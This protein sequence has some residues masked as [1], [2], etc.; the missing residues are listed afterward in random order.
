MIRRIA[1]LVQ[2]DL[3][4]AL[5]DNIIIY[6]LVSPVLLAVVT[7]L[8]IPSLQGMTM[9]FALDAAAEAKVIEGFKAYGKVELYPGRRAGVERVERPDDVAGVVREGDRYAVVVE[10]NEPADVGRM[11]GAVLDRILAGQPLAAIERVSLGK[12]SPLVKETA[13]AALPALAPVLGKR[14]KLR[15][16]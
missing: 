2:K 13:A 10:D 1:V 12:A 6:A 5:R 14:L 16:R 11:T 8:F 3:T 7:A 15:P 4:K 9:T